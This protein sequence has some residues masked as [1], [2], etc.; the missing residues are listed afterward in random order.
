MINIRVHAHTCMTLE[1]TGRVASS[2]SW[3]SVAVTTTQQTNI[4]TR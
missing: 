1:G 4:E 3:Q 2:I